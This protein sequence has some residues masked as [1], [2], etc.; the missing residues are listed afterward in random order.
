VKRVGTPNSELAV[1]WRPLLKWLKENNITQREFAREMASFTGE[2]VAQQ[3]L[4]GWGSPT[5]YAPTFMPKVI[6]YLRSRGDVPEELILPIEAVG[7]GNTIPLY[8]PDN[9]AHVN[10]STTAKHGQKGSETQ[11]IPGGQEG[12][13]VREVVRDLKTGVIAVRAHSSSK[14]ERPSNLIN[15]SDAYAIKCLG[16]EMAPRH[17]HGETLHIAPVSL[18]EI[19][20]GDS[21]II[22]LKGEGEDHPISIRQYVDQDGNGIIVRTP[23]TEPQTIAWSDFEA[24]HLV[25]GSLYK[26]L[27]R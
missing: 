2:T 25:T 27:A 5:G 12:L 22:Y 16:N 18:T 4:S 21:I 8:S 10:F 17:R 24:I 26:T 1:V 13:E 6:D 19:G 9:V 11:G 3:H 20:A 14:I 7:Y 23:C 15:V